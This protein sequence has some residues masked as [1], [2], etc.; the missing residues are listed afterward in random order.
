[1]KK[2]S[3]LIFGLLAAVLAFS[4]VLAGCE[5]P[6]GSDGDGGGGVAWRSELVPDSAEGSSFGIWSGLVFTN[7]EDGSSMITLNGWQWTLYAT[8]DKPAG[9][10]STFTVARY[11]PGDGTT[12]NERRVKVTY[13]LA[14]GGQS[15]EITAAKEEGSEA[16]SSDADAFPTGT[17]ELDD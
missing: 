11:Y 7:S 12:N 14:A 5:D 3:T 9:E 6:N 13:T 16:S 1:M 10:A 8:D 4:M 17:Y 15:F 2:R